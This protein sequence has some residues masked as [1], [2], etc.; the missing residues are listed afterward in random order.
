MLDA[1]PSLAQARLVERDDDD[2]PTGN[3]P[4]NSALTV[5]ASKGH[6]QIVQLL[7]ERGAE[8]YDISPGGYPAVQHAIWNGRDDIAEFLLNKAAAERPFPPSFGVGLDFVLAARGGHIDEVHEHLRRD[9]LAVFR[10]GCI[11]ET[12]LHWAGHNNHAEVV[13]LLLDAGAPIEADAIGLYGGK[14][15]HWASEHAPAAAKLLIDAGADVNARNVLPGELHG[16]TPL[17]QCARQ[18]DD[19]GVCARQLVAVGADANADAH[20]VTPR[21]LAEQNGNA[22]I[23]A[24]LG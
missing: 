4:W 18:R 5:A 23:L 1:D 10:R 24:A 14:P 2:L 22:S 15:L 19:C 21:D 11:G 17:H 16:Y 3:R 20:G 6:L 7:A 12:A 13:Q 8:L 9:P